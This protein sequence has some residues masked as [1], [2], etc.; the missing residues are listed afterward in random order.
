M[1]AEMSSR[2]FDVAIGR[3]SGSRLSQKTVMAAPAPKMRSRMSFEKRDLII[4][5]NRSWRASTGNCERD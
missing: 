5:W 3:I 4:T 1:N 2:A